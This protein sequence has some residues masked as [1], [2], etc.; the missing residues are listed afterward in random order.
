MKVM[1]PTLFNISV[2]FPNIILNRKNQTMFR[3]QSQ[4]IP[5]IS[6]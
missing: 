2:T 3:Y 4:T 1:T 5:L 6:T